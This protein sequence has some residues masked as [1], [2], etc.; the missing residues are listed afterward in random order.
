MKHAHIAL[1]LTPLLLVA[2]ANNTATTS[3]Q[4]NLRNPL[5]AQRYYTDLSELMVTLDVGGDPL[6]KNDG[7]QDIADRTRTQAVKRVE[8]AI[9][10]RQSGLQGTFISE[11]NLTIGAAALVN[12]S[13]FFSPDFESTPGPELH[14]YLSD[15]VDPR[16][17]TFP[18]DTDVDLGLLGNPYGAQEYIIPSA[19]ASRTFRSI[20][21]W[22]TALR[23][24]YGFVQLEKIGN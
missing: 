21:I 20:V 22:D 14:V 8:D 6:L 7:R 4:D 13:V 2:C 23:L 12:G 3:L 17:G 15:T 10:L 18:A 9:Q 19:E 5:F 1:L 11:R 16:T 24:P